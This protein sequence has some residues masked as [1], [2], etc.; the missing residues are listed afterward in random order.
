MNLELFNNLI[1]KVK[2]NNIVEDFI[3]E[4]SMLQKTQ[5]ETKLTVKYRDKMHIERANILN[6]Y[7][8]RTIDEGTMYYVYNKDKEDNMYHLCI[9]E[10]S[11]SHDVIEVKKSEL[12]EKAGV[13]SVLRYKNGK[14][15]LDKEATREVSKQISTM[16]EELLEEQ[17]Q[18]LEKNRV[19]GH[20]YEVL[21]KSGDTVWLIDITDSSKNVKSFEEVDFPKELMAEVEEGSVVKCKLEDGPFLYTLN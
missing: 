16:V 9:C 6:N 5:E 1:N 19:D 20:S 17:T 10:E 13:D 8:K 15:I 12:P 18:Y 11:K 4:L 21:E 7:A 2:E 14:Y 3:N